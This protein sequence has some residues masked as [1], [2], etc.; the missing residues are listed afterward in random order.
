MQE[1]P[2]VSNINDLVEYQ[3]ESVVSKT[4]IKGEKGSITLFAF[5]QGQ[6]LSEHTAPFDAFVHVTDGE[7]EVTVAQE[8][9]VVQAGQMIILPANIPH[10]LQANI[11]F[12]MVL[13][14]VKG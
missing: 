12:K 7:A 10:A 1:S 6:G 3:S 9:Q 11:P 14:M 8:S 2:P 13:V 5:E 4:L